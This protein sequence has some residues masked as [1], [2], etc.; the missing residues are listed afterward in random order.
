MKIISLSIPTDTR[1]KRET[2]N[3]IIKNDNENVAI[4]ITDDHPSYQKAYKLVEDFK[5]G[6]VNN[7]ELAEGL[8]TV[9]DMEK[10]LNEKFERVGGILDGRMS[11]KDSK[12][13]IDYEP[14]DPV[15]E[16]HILRMLKADGTPKDQRE[17]SAFSKFIENLY[18]NTSDYVRKQLFGWMTYEN[19]H[20]TGLTLTA[21]GCII[22]Y[23][24]CT[25][26]VE[27]PLS[28][29][30]GHAIAN[31]VDYNGQIPNV[32]GTIVE[33]PRN[34]VEADPKIACAPGLHVGTYNYAEGWSM[35]VLL[36]VKFN[37]RDV[38]A[39]PE[40]SYAQKIRT[41]RYEV[42]E[43][44]E[45]AYNFTTYEESDEFDE[46]DWVDIYSTRVYS[47]LQTAEETRED[48]TVTYTDKKGNTTTRAVVVDEIDGA[49]VYVTLADG[50]GHRT[51]NL[52]RISDAY[53]EDEDDDSNG[54]EVSD[55]AY[56][57]KDAKDRG[58]DVTFTYVDAKN[59]V[60]HRVVTVGEVTHN[61]LNGWDVLKGA[62]RS[63]VLSNI[64]NLREVETMTEATAEDIILNSTEELIADAITKGRDVWIRYTDARG[65]TTDRLVTPETFS[66]SSSVMT[67]FCHSKKA[68]RSFNVQQIVKAVPALSPIDPEIE[69]EIARNGYS[70]EDPWA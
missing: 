25:G 62:T 9:T 41:C 24:G 3:A 1:T 50:S 32:P 34:E 16:A 60:S 22:G 13:T 28:I 64:S 10:T 57:L 29:R 59:Q 54:E 52:E 51:F 70:D 6:S 11:I 45:S 61:L 33:M 4:S 30:S 55:V 35:G 56:A 14:I 15:L 65:E 42:L 58:A 2:I 12:V 67:A 17:W 47:N 5:N 63:F 43:S 39:V 48:M 38:V 8:M 26:T 68:M 27:A 66:V 49:N 53:F 31:G 40:C 7:E 19:L 37:P 21:D 18:S 69:E 23:K 44:V 36:T 20:G 46:E